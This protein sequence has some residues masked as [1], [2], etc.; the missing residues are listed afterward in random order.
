MS[1]VLI[2]NIS[3]Q[4]TKSR[5]TSVLKLQVPQWLVGIKNDSLA[6]YMQ[7]TEAVHHPH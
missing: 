2:N 1:R 4:S 5:G 6:R 7:C 3:I